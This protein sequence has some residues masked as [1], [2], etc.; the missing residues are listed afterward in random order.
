[1]DS[2][3]I[4]NLSTDRSISF[5]GT[6]L[7]NT[8]HFSDTDIHWNMNK[9]IM[10]KV[11]N[12]TCI[13]DVTSTLHWNHCVHISIKMLNSSFFKNYFPWNEK[14]IS[15]QWIQSEGSCGYIWRCKY[16][17]N[18]QVR[19]KSYQRIFLCPPTYFIKQVRGPDFQ[20]RVRI[21]SISSPGPEFFKHV[22][23]RILPN[24][25]IIYIL[26]TN[27]KIVWCDGL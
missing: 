17:L 3:N 16:F 1:M 19:A 11:S 5:S 18:Y 7:R 25:L 23:F 20:V 24:A 26:M 4:L 21:L 13:S 8:F 15:N 27:G 10:C 9:P 12:V 6:Y 22:R 14:S 2:Y